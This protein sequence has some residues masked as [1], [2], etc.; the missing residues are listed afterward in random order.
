MK[1]K[2][3]FERRAYTF[4]I[5]ASDNENGTK[6]L[7]G[8][9]IVYNSPTDIAGLFQEIIEPGA[10]DSANLKDVPLLVNHNTEMI[11]VARSRRN[12]PNSTMRLIVNERGLDMEAD[13]D[14][15]RNATACELYSAVERGDLDGMSFLFSVR[16]EKW[17]NLESDYP[18]R[19]IQ[20][21]DVI[22]EV[23]AVTWPAYKATTINARSK[24]ALDSARSALDNARQ[25]Q[26]KPLDSGELELL[27]EKSKI[28]G[29]F[30]K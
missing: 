13:I 23:S 6:R 3:K 29:G 12:T 17:E 7:A 24:E 8:T 25:Q 30:K 2:E 20:K 21:L 4:E 11:P 27:K 22:A 26:A 1:N 28:L 19:R 10:L 16:D 15:E 5:R 14:V 18:T 9:P